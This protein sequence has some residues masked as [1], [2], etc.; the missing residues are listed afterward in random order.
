MNPAAAIAAF[1]DLKAELESGSAIVSD[2][3]VESWRARVRAVL[4]RSLGDSNDLV[5]KFDNIWW[6][7]GVYYDGQPESDFID[8]RRSGA[9][10]A[11]AYIEAA[12]FEL[13]LIAPQGSVTNPSSYQS[14]LWENVGALVESED[15]IHL[16]AAVTIYCED[17]IRAWA[18]LGHELV[19]K[20]LYAT[21]LAND[22]VLRLGAVAGEWEGWRML[23]MGLAQAVG[24]VDRHRLERRQDARAYAVGVLGI[25]SLLLT[26]MHAEHA[27]L[28]AAA[29]A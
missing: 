28:I 10:S 13:G 20:G 1:S 14:G 16:P 12:V 8:A 5:A 9:G 4:T 24:N 27:D 2:K 15:W 22:G 23:G 6:S 21:A 26:Q 11:A 25:G 18:G 17:R 19:G 7:P 3:S 29:D